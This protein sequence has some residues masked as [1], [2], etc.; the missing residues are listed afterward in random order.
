MKGLESSRPA[1]DLALELTEEQKR[2]AVGDSKGKSKEDNSSGGSVDEA[3]KLAI[4]C[5][6][7]VGTC[8]QID[9]SLRELK[10]NAFVT[11]MHESLPKA[12]TSASDTIYV[13][14]GDTDEEAKDAYMKWAL[15]SRFVVFAFFAIWYIDNQKNVPPDSS[16]VTS[17]LQRHQ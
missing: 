14:A 12:F 3:T 11:R 4:F 15:S 1:E 9:K 16:T 17:R 13:E 6:R 10:G 2:K 7:L 8:V 5:K